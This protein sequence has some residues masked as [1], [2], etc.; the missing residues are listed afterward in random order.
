MLI[1]YLL[2]AILQSSNLL[3]PKIN[4]FTSTSHSPSHVPTSTPIILQQPTTSPDPQLTSSPQSVQH[5]LA[6][7][8]PP[9]RI[10]RPGAQIQKCHVDILRCTASLS[11]VTGTGLGS[12]SLIVRGVCGMCDL[13]VGRGRLHTVGCRG[14][15]GR[16]MAWG[17]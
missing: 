17:P 14:G 5:N 11:K 16:V 1:S 6:Q 8:Q 12:R 10:P 3:L 9:S 2:Q 4:P 15:F 13:G 7:P